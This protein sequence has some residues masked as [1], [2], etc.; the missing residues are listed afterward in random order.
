MGGYDLP[1]E[2]SYFHFS[3][4]WRGKPKRDRVNSSK[5]GWCGELW[6]N[7]RGLIPSL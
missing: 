5:L 2:A 7:L 3:R 1:P 4:M 6:A